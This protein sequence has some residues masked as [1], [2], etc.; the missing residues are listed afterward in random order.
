MFNPYKWVYN[1]RKYFLKYT[2]ITYECFTRLLKECKA[3]QD[4]IDG[5][6]KNTPAELTLLRMF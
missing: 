1:E 3:K 6:T 2:G 5:N 4:P